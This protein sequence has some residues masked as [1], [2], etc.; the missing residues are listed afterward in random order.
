[1]QPVLND[2]NGLNSSNEFQIIAL[3]KL[4]KSSY[5]DVLSRSASRPS[6]DEENLG[7]VPSTPTDQQPVPNS[8]STN[9][10]L[11]VRS[12]VFSADHS[13]LAW[14]CGY[15]IIKIMKFKEDSTQTSPTS[16]SSTDSNIKKRSSSS[17]KEESTITSDESFIQFQME[18]A[19]PKQAKTRRS[20]II[21]IDCGDVVWSLGFGSSKSCLKHISG[22][23]RPK[24]YRR[25]NFNEDRLLLAVGLSSGKIR[26]YDAVSGSFLFGLF[27][28]SDLVRDLKFTKDGSL[29][30]ASVSRDETI[31]LWNMYDDGN[32]YKTLKGHVGW[33]NACDW[34]P[35]T[36]M[37][38]SVGEIDRLSFG[39]LRHTKL[40]IN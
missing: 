21:E 24:V 36:K 8:H 27:D 35:T 23:R 37:L 18:D 3:G 31:K 13:Y 28:H 11:E 34:S 5:Y 39:T 38:C 26:I 16:P 22:S 6:P 40:S 20:K 12:C 29:Q 30:L 32:M 10:N 15:G 7:V 1:M 2:Q 25:F 17:D 19:P 14:S 33:V 4:P 9:D